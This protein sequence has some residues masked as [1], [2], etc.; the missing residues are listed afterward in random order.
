MWK[1]LPSHTSLVQD[2]LLPPYYNM[3]NSVPIHLFPEQRTRK[4]RS[5]QSKIVIGPF[6]VPKPIGARRGT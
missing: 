4:A 5:I 6:T 3:N 2:E 1:Y